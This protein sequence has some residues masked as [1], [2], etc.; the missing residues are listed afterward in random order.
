[1]AFDDHAGAP[2]PYEV[3]HRPKPGLQPSM[4]GFDPVV[5][6]LPDGVGHDRQELGDGSYHGVSPVSYDLGKLAVGADRIGEERR[7][8]Q[9]S[10]LRQRHVYDLPYWSTAR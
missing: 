10:L 4:V 8:P 3:P 6:I 1:M 2:V 9:V 7:R 5:G